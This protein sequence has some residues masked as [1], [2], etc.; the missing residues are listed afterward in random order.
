MKIKD[1]LLVED[2]RVAAAFI[3]DILVNEGFSVRHVP[4]GK[5]A[6]DAIRSKAPDVIFTDLVMP[7]ISGEELIRQMREMPGMDDLPIVVVTGT[8]SEQH[9][10]LNN[11]PADA[12]IPKT[13]PET[14]RESILS[15]CRQLKESGTISMP[16]STDTADR[17]PPRRIVKE[18]LASREHQERIFERLS[19]GLVVL[20]TDFRILKVNSLAARFL[21]KEAIHL[22]N[23]PFSEIFANDEKKQIE[24][25]LTGLFAREDAKDKRTTV[26]HNNRI[27]DLKFSDFIDKISQKVT[28]GL[29]L[30]EDI[31]ERKLL[32]DTLR[33]SEKRYRTIVNTVPDIIY[34]LDSE[35]RFLFVNFAVEDLGYTRAE[36]IGKS[37]LEI[38]HP[39]DEEKAKYTFNERRT[40]PRSSKGTELR[41]LPKDAKDAR[42]YNVR[43]MP[44][45][46]AARGLYDVP[47][48]DIQE[49]QKR[50]MGTQG[51]AQDITDRKRIEVALV[52]AKDDWERTFD[53]ITELVMLLD[54]EHRIVRINK[55]AADA[56][57]TVKENVLGRKCYEV[58]HL[59]HRPV[60]GCPLQKTMRDRIPH[61]QEIE[62]TNLGGTFI[63]STSPILDRKGEILGY[64]HSLKDIT[65]WKRL[66]AQF[67]EAQKMEAI[68]TLAGGI[69]H[70][71]NNLL[72]GIQGYVSLMLLKMEPVHP[73]FKKLRKIEEQVTSASELTNQLLG[74]A[75]GGKYQI[76]PIE[77]NKLVE[78]NVEMFGRTKKEI[79]THTKLSEEPI[80]IDGDQYQIEQVLLNLYVNAYEAMPGGGDLYVETNPVI[81]DAAD[82]EAYKIQ[83]GRYV[84]I[85]VRDT[86]IGMDQETQARI[87]EPFFTTKEMGRGTGLGL[88][89]VYGIVRN[90][91]G[92][93][94]VES[95]TGKGSTFHIY[96]PISGKA[97][98]EEK[99]ATAEIIKGE[100][101]ILLVDDEKNILDVSAEL[102]ASLGYTVI[103]AAG[104]KEAVDIYRDKKD[105][106]DL[107]VLDMVMPGMRGGEAYDVLKKI[108]PNVKV[109]LSSGYSI[110][111]GA[112]EI[113]ARGGNDFIQKPFKIEIL[114]Q[115]IREVLGTP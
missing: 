7:R 46:V 54:K 5:E 94:E 53:A 11:I 96:I 44:V 30:I 75:R 80:V 64:T 16:L 60:T 109:I 85:S 99:L 10:A 25:L 8:I 100:E 98:K 34:H 18:L 91:H 82:A 74:F 4:D 110:D 48:H 63:C 12:F 45:S 42:I 114:S 22:I 40:R 14:F 23:Q 112:K 104:G 28:A 81:I 56:L 9:D 105:E 101:T 92:A 108:N 76:V 88:A 51:I 107:V 73:H 95:E 113:I 1:I 111:K 2:D 57:R 27:L 15:I 84:R 106:I 43:N 38:V 71:F 49:P 32:E 36:L 83:E 77:L 52:N 6:L 21:G 33:E 68:G 70:D 24:K 37:F 47:D 67:H 35:G 39:D 17:F 59:T 90:H 115:K 72:M 26:T 86:G 19:E 61:S 78:K 93:I 3:K 79:I 55:A 66:E 31:T 58:V 102:L 50:F 13:P 69:A 65:E 29:V 87:F 20:D 62:E 89:S 97:L 41:L 103:T